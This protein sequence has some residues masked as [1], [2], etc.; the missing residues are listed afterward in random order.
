MDNSHTYTKTTYNY[1]QTHNY[2]HTQ[3]D[4]PRDVHSNTVLGNR[5]HNPVA[6]PQGHLRCKPRLAPDRGHCAAPENSAGEF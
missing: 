2:I 1:T 4:T 6:S 3:A 5:K